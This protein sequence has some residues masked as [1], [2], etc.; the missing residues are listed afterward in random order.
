MVNI[1]A[2]RF[3]LWAS[4]EIQRG[5]CLDVLGMHMR[6]VNSKSRRWTVRDRDI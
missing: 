4:E 6:L 2:H 1:D 5:Q 3:E